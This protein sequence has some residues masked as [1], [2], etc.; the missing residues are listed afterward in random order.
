MMLRWSLGQPAAAAAIEE[1]VD[2]ALD[3]GYRTRDLLPAGDGPA[4]QPVG[5]QAMAR[6]IGERIAI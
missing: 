1:A 3:D 5:T 2:R 6:A 4:L